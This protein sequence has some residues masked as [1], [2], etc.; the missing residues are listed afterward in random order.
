MERRCVRAP[1]RWLAGARAELVIEDAATGAPA[2]EIQL[3]WAVP[4]GDEAAIGY[5]LL[6]AWR[7]RGY[8]TR[9]VLL[10][11]LWAFAETGSGRLVA[12]ALPDNVASRRVL[13]RAGFR[14]EGRL[15]SALRA[16]DGSRVDGVRHA[17]VAEDVLRTVRGDAD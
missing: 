12:T 9:A 11:A 5:T 1:G 17:L 8:A 14:S 6:P 15:R 2:G 13:E 3:T 16:A 7:G 4:G 10:L